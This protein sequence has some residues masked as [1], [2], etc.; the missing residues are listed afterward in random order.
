[1]T[2]TASGRTFSCVMQRRAIKFATVLT[3]VAVLGTALTRSLSHIP[4]KLL[5]GTE[6]LTIN[7]DRLA[8]RAVWAFC[9]REDSGQLIRFLPAR[10]SKGNAHAIFDA[11][12]QCYKFHQG[13][14]YSGHYLICRLCGN[15]YRLTQMDTGKASCIP[16]RLPS[17]IQGNQAKISVVDVKAGHWLF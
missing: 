2:A 14:T 16:V 7:L 13:Y 4:C 17:K 10:D 9:Y 6:T 8:P 3:A 12:G 1:L 5:G 11:C 15:R